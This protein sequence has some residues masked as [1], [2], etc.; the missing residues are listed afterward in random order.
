VKVTIIDCVAAPAWHEKSWLRF[1]LGGAAGSFSKAPLRDCLAENSLIVSQTPSAFSSRDLELIASTPLVGLFHISDE[2]YREPLGSYRAFSYVLRQYLHT[3]L[4][5]TGVSTVP[6]GP[7]V[8]PEPAL[9]L[10]ASSLTPLSDRE[11]SVT[12]IGNLVTTRFAAARHLSPFPD[13]FVHTTGTADESR[14]VLSPEE[15]LGK[16]EKSSFVACPMGN[17]N[18]ETFRVYEALEA[19]AVP[20]V[21]T[22]PGF[23]YFRA[24]LGDHPLPSVTRWSQAPELL[25]RLLGDVPALNDLGSVVRRWWTETTRE[26]RASVLGAVRS[27]S[28]VE[29]LD[30]PRRAM[31]AELAKHHNATAAWRRLEVVQRRGRKRVA[32][33]ISRGVSAR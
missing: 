33:A 16:L 27:D 8:G 5:G 15:Y 2:W 9:G 12:F 3:R 4:R 25:E 20:I 14:D 26:V 10:R 7:A 29:V 19:G 24:L 31:L 6:L 18:L 21:E 13:S 22:R 28:R 11:H 1:L 23:D 30:L 32:Q 17:V